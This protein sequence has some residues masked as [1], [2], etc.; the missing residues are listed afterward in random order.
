MHHC[1]PHES[2]AHCHAIWKWNSPCSGSEGC[3]SCA[4]HNSLFSQVTAQTFDQFKPYL[5][6]FLFIHPF[7]FLTFKQLY[8]RAKKT[9]IVILLTNINRWEQNCNDL[10]WLAWSHIL[11][12]LGHF[13]IHLG[14]MYANFQEKIFTEI[15][16]K[17][18][19]TF[20]CRNVT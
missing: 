20:H 8:S 17:M 1:I 18:F 15:S 16:G 13:C 7:L 19:Q 11:L 6:T 3:S 12:C 5:P 2:K 14:T 4:G 9:K 10:Q